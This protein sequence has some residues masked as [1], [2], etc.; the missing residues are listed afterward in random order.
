MSDPNLT[1]AFV[2]T[3]VQPDLIVAGRYKL[4]EQI[5]E[6]GM[7]AVWVAE[8]R[9]P[10]RRLVALKL[11]KPGMDSKAVLARF[12]A[13]RQALAVMDHPNIAK[14]F[15]GGTTELGR[16]F[17]VMELV[18]G[19]ALTEY[20]DNRRLNIRDRL[21]LFM[22]VCSAVQHAHQKGIIHR[23][24]KPSN[25]LVTEHDGK[26]VPKVIDFGLAKALHATA[27]L[28][29]RTLHTAYGTVVGTPR[30]MAPEQVGVNALD[31]DTRTDIY[32]LGVI[33]YELLTG[34]TPV[35]KQRLNQAAWD[36]VQ[37]MI[38]E[39]EPPR[40]S[41]RL[42]STDSL[43][44]LAA[45]RRT[46]PAGLTKV[47]RGD[48]DWIVM[49]AL[50]KNRSRRYE[51]ASGF[52][53]DVQR[54]L[55]GEP[56]LAA[57]PSVRYR[58]GKW[59]RRNKTAVSV[60][61]ALWLITLVLGGFSTL[62]W[63]KAREAEGR[64][65]VDR[66]AAE[67]AQREA[68]ASA[69]RETK[70]KESAWHSLYVGR[71]QLA[72][73]AWRDGDLGRMREILREACPKTGQNDLRAFEWHYL[74]RLSHPAARILDDKADDVC[75]AVFSSDGKRVIGMN[76]NSQVK[77]YDAATGQEVSSL[78]GH[79]KG[80]ARAM[81]VS[82][83]G[84]FLAKE[85]RPENE[86][87][88]VIEVW[89]LT[90]ARL[91][92]TLG[93][94][95]GCSSLAFSPDGKRLAVGGQGYS[96]MGSITL[97]QIELWN[98][99]TRQRERTVPAHEGYVSSVEFAP[100]GKRLASCGSDFAKIWD[101]SSGKQV[102][103][104]DNG[105][106][107]GYASFRSDGAWLA[108]ANGEFVDVWDTNTGNR[109]FTLRGHA[110]TLSSVAFS[111][112]GKR[113]AI[114]GFDRS[115]GI[116]DV[117][118]RKQSITIK[119]H[120]DAVWNVAFSPDG[121]SLVSSSRD[122]TIKV[123]DASVNPE[124]L[125]LDGGL[126]VA[127]SPDNTKIASSTGSRTQ[128]WELRTGNR[129][130][131]FDG[132]ASSVAFSPDGNRLAV[133]PGVFG[134]ANGPTIWGITNGGSLPS[135]PKVGNVKSLDYSPDGKL[136]AGVEE[137]RTVVWDD[138]LEHTV[139]T[140]QGASHFTFDPTGT[141]LAGVVNGRVRL[142][143]TAS[144][145]EVASLEIP[146]GK[147]RCLAFSHDG[148]RLAAGTE[149]DQNKVGRIVVW[150]LQTRSIVLIIPVESGS[151]KCLAFSM[152]NRRLAGSPRSAGANVQV[153]GVVRMWELQTGQEVLALPVD[154]GGI[155]GSGTNL[156][157]SPD[158]RFLA[159]AGPHELRVWNGSE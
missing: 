35:E 104:F 156:V 67:F 152:D 92:M 46:E 69:G 74:W 22:E 49:K 159:Y 147:A 85:G 62:Q 126:S 61:A 122:S 125:I 7:G 32:A 52:A 65:V 73:A 56:V 51:T 99:E 127:I 3:E 100:D 38:R 90:T 154:V 23:D 71:M 86:V 33:L 21:G 53:M 105:N 141:L 66:D 120:A 5:G 119:G 29:E 145:A 2:P 17:F 47:V 18:K 24:L 36:D 102:F 91:L 155:S 41:K 137:G 59:A 78:P 84:T 57:P 4:L 118:K 101:A 48:L 128:I 6:G 106:R 43:P 129:I 108:C 58:L 112:D 14:V 10:V 109:V 97:A 121:K 13:E 83:D 94:A 124:A 146:D 64:A 138:L 131:S 12:E 140:F 87:G 150:N 44:S 93:P 55:A 70:E 89:D 151:I 77:V 42:N 80:F 26:P 27:A 123:W 76:H 40:P 82:P 158:G 111:P 142:W 98:L 95:Q 16:P 79:R 15:D 157:F 113:L 68:L 116:W 39:E 88:V 81:A 149:G 96:S 139:R 103:A 31:V 60:A 11:I 117:A 25:V 9:E 107:G 1:G 50:E 153:P 54:Y 28:T 130:R 135:R 114:S 30:Y 45:S 20:C 37:R 34:T 136:I 132:P 110:A 63:L 133:A 134:P 75:K 144:D 72:Q 8:Q 115:I 19:L 143:R 148:Q